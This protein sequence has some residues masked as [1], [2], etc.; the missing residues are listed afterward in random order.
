MNIVFLGPPGSGKGT[1]AKKLA[2]ANSIPHLSTGDIFR[3][4]ISAQT[5]VGKEV[6]SFVESGKLVPDQLVS[7]VVFEKLGT[8]KQGFLLDGYPR[9]LEQAKDLDVF[10]KDRSLTLDAVFFFDVDFD[11]LVQRL[12]AR[13]QCPGCKEVFNLVARTPKRDG[14][15]DA[16]G[17]ALVQRP[18][19]K[20]E[21][22]KDRLE[23]YRKQTQPVLGHY[24]GRPEYHPINAARTIDEVY[25][26]LTSRLGQ[27]ARA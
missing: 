8:L 10:L 9:T 11:E 17:G 13:R 7:K 14:T 4:A 5:P 12:S 25:N 16:C 20:A 24:E 18:D 3:E 15:C 23:V 6:K 1:Q 2:D 19:D 22:V 27:K 26:E 21:V